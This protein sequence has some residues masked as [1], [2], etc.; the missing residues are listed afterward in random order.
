MIDPVWKMTQRI[1]PFLFLFSTMTQRIELF[2][3]DS[4]NWASFMNLFSTRVEL[5]FLSDSKNWT[6]FQYYSKDFEYFSKIWTLFEYDSKIEIFGW[7]IVKKLN[8]F[9][10]IMTQRIQPFFSDMTQWNEIWKNDSKSLTGFFNMTYRIEPLLFSLIW[11]KELNLVSKKT[12]SKNRN[13]LSEKWLK[14]LNSL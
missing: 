4:F 9:Q 12:D 2:V 13:L 11:F 7:K 6:F 10:R 14:G 3:N 8:S 5:L 1:E